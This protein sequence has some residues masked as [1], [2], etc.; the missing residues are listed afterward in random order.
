MQGVFNGGELS[1]PLL[2]VAYEPF[3]T[4]LSIEALNQTD[5]YS[6][7][8]ATLETLSIALAFNEAI[9]L[10][11]DG[12]PGFYHIRLFVDVL[13]QQALVLD[14]IVAVRSSTTE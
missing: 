10:A 4:P 3:P 8:A 6:S 13:G 11:E 5:S 1:R 2:N 12:Q 14:H 9:T 7:A